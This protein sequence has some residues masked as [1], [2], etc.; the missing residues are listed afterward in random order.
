MD[1]FLPQW[2]PLNIP[3]ALFISIILNIIIAISGVIPSAFLTAWNISY[4]GFTNGLVVSIIGEAAGAIVSFLLYR[5]GLSK[6]TEKHHPKNRFIDK[7]KTTGNLE[8]IFLVIVLRVLPFVPSG[9]VTLA[10]AFSK[11]GL[12]SFSIASTAGKIPS[13]FIEAYSVNKVLQFETEWQ[14]GILIM[15]FL[16][17]ILYRFLKKKKGTPSTGC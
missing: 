16:F 6:L 11:M 2:I 1:T 10:A 15:L 13:L 12:I 14:I 17:Y 5:K 3:V 8:G 4:F 9:A 7:L